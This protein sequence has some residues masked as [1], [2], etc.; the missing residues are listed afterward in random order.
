MA[1]WEPDILGIHFFQKK[2]FKWDFMSIISG[3]SKEDSLN[4]F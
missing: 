3:V 2:V 4:N 1:L